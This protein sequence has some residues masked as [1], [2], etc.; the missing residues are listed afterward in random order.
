MGPE[1]VKPGRG[2]EQASRVSGPLGLRRAVDRVATRHHLERDR[3][4]DQLPDRRCVRPF[5]QDRENVEDRVSGA[6]S[7]ITERD[8]RAPGLSTM[9][10]T[11]DRSKIEGESR[12]EWFP[13]N[14]SSTKRTTP[15]GISRLNASAPDGRKN[16]SF[17]PH[18]AR[19]DGRCVRK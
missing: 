4:L 18:T 2:D 13:R 14:G 11:P 16:G 19:S 8:P 12:E 7:V 3:R 6:L 1:Q 17:L 9:V 15:R 5:P 10:L